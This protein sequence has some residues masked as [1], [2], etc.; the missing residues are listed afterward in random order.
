ME[1]ITMLKPGYYCALGTPLDEN[2]NIIPKSLSAHIESQ[3]EAGASGLL[4]MGSMG[5]LGCIKTSQ[6][7]PALKTAVEAVRGRLP[8]MVG[9]ADN[10][11]ARI[12]DRME[13]VN[14]YDVLTVA[15]AP[16][17]FALNKQTALNAFKAAAAATKHDLY[18]YDHPSTAR[19]KLNYDDVLEL[20]KVQNIKGIKTGDAVLIKSLVDSKEVKKDFTPIFSNS[21]LFTMGW[22]YGVR[23]LLDGIFACFPAAIK[24]ANSAL[25]SGDLEGGKKK[26]DGIMNA[27]DKM[28]ATALWPMFSCAMNLLGFPGNFAPDYEPVLDGEGREL[29]KSILQELGEI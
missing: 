3:I 15:T 12:R 8:L 20:S 17:Y 13:V 2:G 1:E 10:S 22:A 19:Y 14:K 4:L 26:M 9:V 11:I 21:D 6:Y 16:Y 24:A 23:H 7:E 27:R 29:M 5:M 18:L 28:L 25:L